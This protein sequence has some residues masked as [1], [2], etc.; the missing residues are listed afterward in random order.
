MFEL[1]LYGS[2]VCQ[3]CDE[4]KQIVLVNLDTQKVRFI[5]KD[6]LLDDQLFD[7]Y[8]YSIPVLSI[9]SAESNEQRGELA[10]PFDQEAFLSWLSVHIA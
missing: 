5:E 4:A 2:Q 3:L 7:R 10:W 9:V 8:R 1:T 6:I